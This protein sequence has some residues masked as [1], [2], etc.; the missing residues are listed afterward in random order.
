MPELSAHVMAATPGAEM[1]EYMEDSR[2]LFEE[3]FRVED[4]YIVISPDEPGFGLRPSR[5]VREK[6]GID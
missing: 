2:P 4:G 1:L 3:P 5:L 6:L